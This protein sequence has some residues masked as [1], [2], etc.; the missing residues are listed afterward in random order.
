MEWGRLMHLG[1]YWYYIGVYQGVR[2]NNYYLWKSI[3]G[4]SNF[5]SCLK[6]ISCDIKGDYERVKLDI[7]TVTKIWLLF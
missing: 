1:T 2:G 6:Y 3:D 5:S 7:F 4:L